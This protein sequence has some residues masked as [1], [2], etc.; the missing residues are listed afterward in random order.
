MTQLSEAIARY[1]KILESEPYRDLSWTDELRKRMQE[2]GLVV[3]S[4]PVCPVLR[5]H[6]L[7]TRQY[8]NLVK[9]SE[10][11]MAAI[12]RIKRMAL[13]NPSLQN[14]MELLP[15]EKMLAAIDPGYHFLS[16]SSLL[17]TSLS[18]GHMR[19][20][21]YEADAPMGLAYSELLTQLFLETGPVKEFRKRYNLTRMPGPKALLN[22]LLKAYKDFGGSKQPNIAIV[23]LKQPFQTTESAEYGLLAEA[24]RKLG[25]LTEV[26]N[27]DQLEYKN[28]VLRRGDFSID[29]VYRCVRVSDFLLRHDLSH[30]L[31]RAYRDRAVCMV[32]SFR[33]ELARKKAIFDLLTDDAL[34]QSFPPAE[35]KVI[36]ESI[37]WTR[38]V[39]ETTTTYGDQRVDLLDF[40][41][42]NRQTLVLRPNDDSSDLHEYRG[43]E[44]DD[45]GWERALKTAL[46][47]PY[48]V[49]EKTEPST[50]V[51]PVMQWG[52]VEMKTVR[53]D[54]LP[55]HLIGRVQG[56]TS[57]ISAVDSGR[58]STLSGVVPTFLVE[59]K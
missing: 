37:P 35:R 22:S 2:S 36:R 15:A 51:F 21:D 14:R 56:A 38:V 3:S 11:L 57:W 5:P 7:T 44:T 17:E 29:L 55:H 24:F 45:A 12:D 43:W 58:F 59:P 6:F 19:F 46:R 25:Y 1:H 31:V 28:R 33:A 26:V 42:R 13:A 34:T 52:S 20:L 9:S 10:V 16:V 8:A 48:V 40:I 50:A 4:R 49:Q 30:P 39:H 47:H 41:Q 27:L 54:V 18:N 23:E 53:V 32:N